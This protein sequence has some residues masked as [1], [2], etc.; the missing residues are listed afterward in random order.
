MLCPGP[1]LCR[2]RTPRLS[3]FKDTDRTRRTSVTISRIRPTH[4]KKPKKRPNLPARRSNNDKR[5]LMANPDP[6]YIRQLQRNITYQGS[7]KHKKHPHLYKLSH[8]QGGTGDAT[9][10][11]RDANFMPK[12]I[13]SIGQMIQRGLQAGLVGENG[14]IW[15][16]SDNGWIYEARVTNLQKTEY[17]GYPVRSTEPI[18][19]KVY[20][21]FRDW[22]HGG[23]DSLARQAALQCKTR[24]GFRS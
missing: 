18:A 21:R 11:D 24:Y 16:I 13:A 23:G 2:P 9:L 5:R 22:A 4:M 8:F 17:H 15:A 12:D 6:D 10:C 3:S 1:T 19:E 7:A 20:R 14:L